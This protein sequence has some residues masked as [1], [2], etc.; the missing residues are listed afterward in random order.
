VIAKGAA[1]RPFQ[2]GDKIIIIRTYV[3]PT[4]SGEKDSGSGSYEDRDRY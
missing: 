2:R 3:Q 1:A 4:D